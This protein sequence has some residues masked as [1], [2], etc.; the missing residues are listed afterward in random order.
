VPQG[1]QLGAELPQAHG[2]ALGR[3]GR[4]RVRH[5]R[6]LVRHSR[7]DPLPPQGAR[8]LAH[9]QEPQREKVPVRALRAALLH[10]QGRETAPRGAHGQARLPLP[11]LSA[12]VRPQGPPRA[13]HQEEPRRPQAE[14]RRIGGGRFGGRLSGARAA[15]LES[16]GPVRN[17]APAAAAAQRGGASAVSAPAP[18]TAAAAASRTATTAA[19]VPVLSGAGH[20]DGGGRRRCRGPVPAGRAEPGPRGPA[21]AHREPQRGREQPLG[22]DGKPAA[23]TA[24]LQPGVSAAGAGPAAQSPAVAEVTFPEPR[25]SRVQVCGPDLDE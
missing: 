6:P 16:A 19:A 21:H 12:A 8:R 14:K 20:Q 3:G 2:R 7:R 22:A 13:A 10:S 11:V 9:R 18:A 5:V 23:A 15:R 17:A 24:W 25:R 4:A 1:V